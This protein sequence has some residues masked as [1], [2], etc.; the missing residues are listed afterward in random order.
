MHPRFWLAIVTLAVATT[1]LSAA[2]LYELAFNQLKGNGV[3]PF[4]RTL[5]SD[6][7]MRADALRAEIE[8]LVRMV[9]TYEGYEALLQTKLSERVERQIFVLHFEKA[10]LFLRLDLYT[11]ERGAR[12]VSA[13][14]S[15]HASEIL[16]E[17]LLR[18]AGY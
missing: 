11:P 3:I 12:Y 14:V 16:P 5:F 1:G 18:Q 9:G 7:S 8:P 2:P 17:A 4:S 13:K 10:P 6:D 15:V